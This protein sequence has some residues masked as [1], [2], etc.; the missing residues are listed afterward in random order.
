MTNT[1]YK[2]RGILSL[3]VEWQFF[4]KA[5]VKLWK[6]FFRF[7]DFDEKKYNSEKSDPDL[8]IQSAFQC[9]YTDTLM[10][11]PF[12]VLSKHQKF[13]IQQS[14]FP[15]SPFYNLILIPPS[16]AF[17]VSENIKSF[18]NLEAEILM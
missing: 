6:Y 5:L 14:L 1:V 7:T 13:K 11:Q 18:C 16:I 2:T 15:V 12:K 8:S 10:T 3:V 9:S 4:Y 17:K